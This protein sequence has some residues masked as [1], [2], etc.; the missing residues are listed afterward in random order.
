MEPPPVNQITC[1]INKYTQS[2]LKQL[3]SHNESFPGNKYANSQEIHFIFL[4]FQSQEQ[5]KLSAVRS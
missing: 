4:I 3:N 2:F 5:K 1:L